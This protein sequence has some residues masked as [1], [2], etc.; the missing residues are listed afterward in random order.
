[1][2]CG[3]SKLE[4]GGSKRARVGARVE[5]QSESGERRVKKQ[6]GETE[7]ETEWKD[8]ASVKK[9]SGVTERRDRA[10][11]ERQSGG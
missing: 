1:M 8:R 6:R 10:R 2:R 3:D 11:A 5:R 7:R 9:Q 4:R